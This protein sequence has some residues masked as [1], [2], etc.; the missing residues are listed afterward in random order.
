LWKKNEVMTN[1]IPQKN[2]FLR[3]T[4]Q[5][6]LQNL[7]YIDCLIYIVTG[8]AEDRDAAIVTLRDI[9][10]QYKDEEGGQLFDEIEKTN[11]GG[12]YRF[13]FHE[14]KIES[15][16]NMLNNLDATLDAFGE[17]YDCDV[18]F[19]YMTSLPISAVGRVLKSAPT[20]FWENHFSAFKPN[21]IPAEIDMQELRYS[22]NKRAPWVRASYIDEAKGRNPASNTSPTVASTSEQ[23]QDNNDMESGI[24][25]G[26]NQ[27]SRPVSQPGTISG[28]SNLKRKMEEIYRDRAAFKIE[29]SKLEEEVSTV[30]CSLTKY[31]EDIVGI[32]HDMTQMST[33]LRSEISEI[34]NMILNMS[35][36]KRGRKQSKH[37]DSE[38]ASTSSAEHGG[39]EPMEVYDKLA[40][41]METSWNSMC[42]SENDR[43]TSTRTRVTQGFN[44][45]SQGKPDGAY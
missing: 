18:N 25:D 27:S 13:F 12:T 7:N 22:T 35:A 5:H 16:D 20:A 31:T 6:I 10:Y 4:K 40:H 42:E 14:R 45:R 26:S 24:Q 15:V 44:T 36:N 28:L 3:S 33:S 37:K 8:S 39:E 29:Q 21:G 41:D 30:T 34:K 1:I 23:G 11:K 32:R 17:W 19:R 38:V 9:F 43:D 2:N